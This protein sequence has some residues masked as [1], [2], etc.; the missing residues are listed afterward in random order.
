MVRELTVVSSSPMSQRIRFAEL[1]SRAYIATCMGAIVIFAMKD[2]FGDGR[3][4]RSFDAAL[5]LR[6]IFATIS[7]D[8][9]QS[10]MT[11]L[12]DRHWFLTGADCTRASTETVKAPTS[13]SGTNISH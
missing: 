2:S 10:L 12:D 4:V 13:E 11:V 3:V 6:W 7:S 9:H 8:Q 5:I 1:R